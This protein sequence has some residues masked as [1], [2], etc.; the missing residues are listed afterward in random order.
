ML[1]PDYYFESVYEIPFG[2]LWEKGIRGFIFDIDNT[3]TAYDE[4]GP[5]TEATELLL[6][7]HDM[8]F[9]LCLLTNNTKRRLASFNQD[10]GLPGFANALKPFTFGIKK[11][12]NDMELNSSQI[13]II[14][15][16]LLTDIWAGKNAGLTTILVK[17]ITQRDFV[18]VK[19]KRIIEKRM[20]KKFFANLERQSDV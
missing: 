9:R 16:Q 13:A 7:L 5:S 6:R 1:E 15:D 8:G 4:K 17:P 2:K 12:I 18:F 20:L 19:F 11:A 14:G 10:L 3:L